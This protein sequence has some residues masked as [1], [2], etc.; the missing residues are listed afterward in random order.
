MTLSVTV[1][2]KSVKEISEGQ[3]ARFTLYQLQTFIGTLWDQLELGYNDS[4]IYL[5]ISDFL[6]PTD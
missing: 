3:G 4:I 2:S 5:E 1:F 6:Y